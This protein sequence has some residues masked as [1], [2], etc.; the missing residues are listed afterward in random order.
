MNEH[1]ALGRDIFIIDKCLRVY[2]KNAL[3]KYEITTAEAMVILALYDNKGTI[4]ENKLDSIHEFHVKKTQDQ[5]ISELQYDKAAMTRTMQLLEKEGYVVRTCNPNDNRSY[6]F[7]LTDKA[8]GFIPELLVI[9]RAVNELL[10]SG[11]ENLDIIK[12]ATF[13]MAKNAKLLIMGE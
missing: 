9:L 3:K 12:K 1:A 5:I 10:T 8:Y 4:S 13:K 6:L 11:V 7:S 2:L